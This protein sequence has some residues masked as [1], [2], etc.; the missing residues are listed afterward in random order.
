MD[1]VSILIVVTIWFVLMYTL[2]KLLNSN[3]KNN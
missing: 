1:L 2:Q 3:E